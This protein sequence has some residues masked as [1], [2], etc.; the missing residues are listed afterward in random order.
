M[1]AKP[2][3]PPDDH[4]RALAQSLDCM[5][6]EDFCALAEVTPI[7]AQNWR[8]RREGPAYTMLGNRVLYPVPKVA[9]FVKERIRHRTSVP[10]KDML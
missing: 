9:E 10:A 2:S 8:K 4:I 1:A 3:T 5:I 6:E 7:T